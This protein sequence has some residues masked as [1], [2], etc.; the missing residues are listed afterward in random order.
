MTTPPSRP[1]P[2]DDAPAP[3]SPPLSLDGR[4]RLVRDP[5]LHAVDP[6][7]PPPA[8]TSARAT[9]PLSNRPP[10]SRPELGP[11]TKRSG[12][13]YV[14]GAR[15]NDRYLL[16]RIL[17]EGSVATVW[18]ARCIG[19]DLDVAVKVLNRSS[20][21]ENGGE[22]LQ[23]E[24]QA[25]ARVVHPAAVRVFAFNFTTAGDPFMVM[26]RLHGAPLSQWLR[27]NGP[28]APRAAVEL[29]LPVAEALIVAHG[30]GVIHRD[31]RPANI[32]MV[33]GPWGIGP[34]LIDFGQRRGDEATYPVR[35][36]RVPSRAPAAPAPLARAR[37][38]A[39]EGAGAPLRERGRARARAG[40]VGDARRGGERRAGDGA[41]RPLAG[42]GA[43]AR[44]RGAALNV[45]RC[46][47]VGEPRA[48]TPPP[49]AGPARSRS[50]SERAPQPAAAARASAASKR[51]RAERMPR[52]P[53]SGAAAGGTRAGRTRLPA[54]SNGRTGREG[55]RGNRC[56]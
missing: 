8:P 28:R 50:R 31:V 10:R 55:P 52:K 14:P 21:P 25:T 12:N 20:A 56:R 39:R 42:G 19:L 2:N 40:G 29:L 27:E 51:V 3:M 33:P 7:P 30:E 1:Q 16:T 44:A 45:E 26:E 34:K 38:R 5:E 18:E 47:D 48:W 22:R 43:D 6:T 23:K 46:R 17:G 24:A 9:S 53:S 11:T 35:A 49:L 15:L 36:R 54:P 32:L 4:Y 37:A 13:P 41:R